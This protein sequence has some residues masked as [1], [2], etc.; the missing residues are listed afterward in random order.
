M[1]LGKKLAA[2]LMGSMLAAAGCADGATVT[3]FQ[4]DAPDAP[5]YDGIGTAGSGN[6][7]ESDSTTTFSG[8]GIGWAGSGN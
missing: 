1:H 5:A 4:I 2:I 8:D 3:G 6:R 7:T